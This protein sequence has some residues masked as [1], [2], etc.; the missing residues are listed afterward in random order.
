MYMRSQ[1]FFVQLL[2]KSTINLCFR[3]L[4]AVKK[5]KSNFDFSNFLKKKSKIIFHDT[6]RV[7]VL[8]DVYTR[9]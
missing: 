1:F 6:R 8:K 4:F 9:K 5:D 3:Y 2:V 7:I